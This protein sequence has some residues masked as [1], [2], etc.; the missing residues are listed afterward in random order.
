MP[1]SSALDS[2]S[3]SP[4]H[5]PLGSLG[6]GSSSLTS[7]LFRRARWNYVRKA[8]FSL[9]FP[10]SVTPFRSI[11]APFRSPPFIFL[12]S[13]FSQRSS[14]QRRLRR[15]LV[16]RFLSTLTQNETERLH[17][18]NPSAIFL[19]SFSH[20]WWVRDRLTISHRIHSTTFYFIYSIS[21]S[22]THL[23]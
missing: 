1:L 9:S 3:L 13:P 4:V 20:R 15:T 8:F 11:Y 2:P 5:I 18:L 10:T 19:T 23:R 7:G 6:S 21:N 12:Y 14:Y 22:Q 16:G 17:L